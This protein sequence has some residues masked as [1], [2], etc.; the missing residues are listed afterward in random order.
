[1][2]AQASHFGKGFIKLGIFSHERLVL[3]KIIIIYAYSRLALYS[4]A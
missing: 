2:T 4:D 1:M 3:C